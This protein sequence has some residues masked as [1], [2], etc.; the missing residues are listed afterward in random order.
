LSNAASELGYKLGGFA[1]LETIV[2]LRPDLLLLSGDNIFAEDQGTALLLH[3]ALEQLYP[4]DKRIVIP[5]QLTV[6]GGPMIADA[7]T[8]LVSELE[9]VEH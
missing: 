8:R 9:R 3:P 1:S 6:C 2:N 7:L 4:P 5:E